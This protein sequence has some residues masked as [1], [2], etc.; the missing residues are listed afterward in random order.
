[1]P[2]LFGKHDGKKQL[3]RP[4]RRCKDNIKMDLTKIMWVWNGFTWLG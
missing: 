4:R 2:I 1:M 3:E